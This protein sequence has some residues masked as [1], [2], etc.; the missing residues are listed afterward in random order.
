MLVR[1]RRDHVVVN[2]PGL[3]LF[4]EDS[5]DFFILAGF[6]LELRRQNISDSPLLIDQYLRSLLVD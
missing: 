3:E 1:W 6:R 4:K 5:F 2:C